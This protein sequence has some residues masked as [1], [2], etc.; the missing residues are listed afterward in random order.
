[1]K[2]AIVTGASRG[3]GAATARKLATLGYAVCV[4]YHQSQEEAKQVVES[5]VAAGGKAFAV[6]ANM[7]VEKD[8]LLLFDAVDRQGGTLNALVNN[9]AIN[10][11][12]GSGMVE[13]MTWRSV[14]FTFQVNTT[15]V[16]IACREA[17]KRMKK[18]SG[19]GGGGG[20][21][22]N[23]SSEAARFGGNRMAHY[24]ASKAALN[25]FTVAFARE[26]AAHNVRVNAISPG[27]IDTDAHKDATPERRAA[28]EA[29]LPMGRMGTPEEAAN[30]IAWLLSDEASYV[31]GSI[32][33]VAGGR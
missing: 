22:V 33:T 16:F 7:G 12:E 20:A 18:N 4:N 11:R 30:T 17:L 25:T 6:Q 23:V 21:I 15:G 32:L 29:S 5:I 31:S 1:M 24:A 14:D 19:K 13:D 8:I 10:P 3:I 2:T 28:L 27:I 9:A 26:A